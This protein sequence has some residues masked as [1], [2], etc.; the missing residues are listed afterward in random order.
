MILLAAVF[1][2]SPRHP[3]T[4]VDFFGYLLLLCGAAAALIGGYAAISTYRGLEPS[5]RRGQIL[6]VTLTGGCFVIVGLAVAAVGVWI[7]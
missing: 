2:P 6:P 3:L 1:T 7:F 4:W 5:R